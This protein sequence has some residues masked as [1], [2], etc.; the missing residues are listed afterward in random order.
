M[1][2]SQKKQKTTTQE[3]GQTVAV[4]IPVLSEGEGPPH[5]WL[6]ILCISK[7][8]KLPWLNVDPEF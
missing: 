2:R 3:V 5:L 4:P 6:Y 1:A 8:M 7:E